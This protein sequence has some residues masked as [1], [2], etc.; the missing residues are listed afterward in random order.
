MELCRL[1]EASLE[2]CVAQAT[3]VLDT[4]GVLIYPTD[5]LYGLGADALSDEAVE[6]VRAVKNR[7]DRKP[8]H[9]I[10]ADLAMAEKYGEVNRTARKLAKA[11][12]PG[13]LTLILK[14]RANIDSGIARGIGTFGIRIPDS[15]FCLALARAFGRPYTTT[16]AN[17]SG[18]EPSRSL[19]PILAS[20]AGSGLIDLVVSNGELPERLPSTVVDVSADTPNVLREGAISSERIFEAIR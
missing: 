6:K 12:L 11:F 14:K 10:V 16:S 17:R 3:G 15:E 9:A 18:E 2:T 7:P 13:P 4:G 5:T 8:I 19:G 20:L 1:E